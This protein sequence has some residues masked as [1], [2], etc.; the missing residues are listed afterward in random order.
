MKLVPR[1]LTGG[2]LAS[3]LSFQNFLAWPEELFN[4]IPFL[5]LHKKLQANSA[6]T[7]DF[8]NANYS[9]NWAEH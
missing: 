8:F 6:Q 4:I 7:P 9:P 3:R 1:F 5:F 2:G